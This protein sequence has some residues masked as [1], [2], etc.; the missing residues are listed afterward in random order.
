M[1]DYPEKLEEILE[2]FE[3]ITD[4]NERADLLIHY[5]DQFKPVPE[6]VATRPFPEDHR[7]KACESEAYVWATPQPDGTLKFDFAVENPQGLSAKALSY[8]L[9]TSLSGAP[10]EQVTQISPE[11]VYE[12]FGNDLSMGKGAGLT[13]IVNMVK[14]FANEHLKHSRS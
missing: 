10:L 11:I 14:H 4:R 3:A 2:D 5:G 8:I 1:A 9:S 13:G 7:V 6:E 12:L